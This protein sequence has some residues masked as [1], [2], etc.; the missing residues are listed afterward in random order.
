MEV[1]SNFCHAA[2]TAAVRSRRPFTVLI[3]L[4]YVP[5]FGVRRLLL[6]RVKWLDP[7][8]V[9][10]NT[11]MA[12]RECTSQK[13]KEAGPAFIRRYAWSLEK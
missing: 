13:T 8:P 2:R 3:M 1:Y 6:L 11:R 10:G 4:A 5:H 12:S 7:F 9:F